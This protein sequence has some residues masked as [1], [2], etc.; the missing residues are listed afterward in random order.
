MLWKLL[1]LIGVLLMVWGAL[2]RLTGAGAGAVE[3]PRRAGDGVEDL[4]RCPR[5]GGWR[6]V[7][8]PCLCETPPT[9]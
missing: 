7:G 8:A 9:P 1:T 3:P 5:C 4:V 6:A 2:R